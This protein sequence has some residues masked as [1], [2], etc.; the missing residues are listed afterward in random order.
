MRAEAAYP[1]DGP[2]HPPDTAGVDTP[3]TNIRQFP[4][5]IPSSPLWTL[6]QHADVRARNDCSRKRLRLTLRCCWH[7][8]PTAAIRRGARRW[9]G[10]VLSQRARCRQAWVPCGSKCLGCGI[11]VAPGFAFT[12]RCGP[13]MSGGRT[14]WRR[15]G[16][17]CTCK[18]ARRVI[19]R[20]PD[21]PCGD[22]RRQGCPRRPS[23]G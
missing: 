4:F 22:Q 19:A 18:A 9:C 2:D 10:M 3:C 1:G 15:C 14:V 13:R 11:A 21:R 7:Q 16:R 23:V 6:G 17:G 12:R 8:M 5:H 20:R